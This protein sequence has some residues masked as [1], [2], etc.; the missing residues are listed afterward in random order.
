[1]KQKKDWKEEVG[2]LGET[3]HCSFLKRLHWGRN[4]EGEGFG[5]VIMEKMS[6]EHE[7]CKYTGG[8]S[9]R[10]LL[11]WKFHAGVGANESFGGELRTSTVEMSMLKGRSVDFSVVEEWR[12]S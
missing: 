7:V 1:M 9:C 11:C 5:R 10:H 8:Y 12:E 4:R 3:D 6:A 2:S